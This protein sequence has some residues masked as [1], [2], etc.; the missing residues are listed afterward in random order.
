MIRRQPI[1]Y[2]RWHGA[3]MIV[4]ESVFRHPHISDTFVL[5]AFTS[6][7]LSPDHVHLTE[8]SGLE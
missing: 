3:V 7:K 5:P 6:T 4:F 8:K 2:E 1:W